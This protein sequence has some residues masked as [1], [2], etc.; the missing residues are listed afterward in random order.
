M[1]KNMLAIFFI[2]TFLF[3]TGALALAAKEDAENLALL[4][5]VMNYKIDDSEYVDDL[6]SL[7]QNERFNRR[8][9]N[10][11]D[12][13]SNKRTKNSINKKVMTILERAGKDLRR[14]L[15]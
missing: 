1:K 7:R 4:M 10:M 11:L 6:E 15:D 3:P 14:V 12:K 5:A 8:L 13:L 2:V 9:R